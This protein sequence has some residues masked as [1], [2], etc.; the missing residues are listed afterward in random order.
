MRILICG[1]NGLLGQKLVQLLHTKNIEFLA[2]S[3]NSNK[4]SSIKDLN[5]KQVDISN[6]NLINDTILEYE[7]GIIINASGMTN[8]D[9]CNE[10]REAC[11]MNNVEGVKNLIDI[12]NKLNAHLIQVSTDF[13]FS[14]KEGPYRETDIPNPANFYGQSKLDAEILVQQFCKKWSIIRTVLVYG[15]T[16]NMSRS[17]IVLWVKKSLE[18]MKAIRVVSDQFR[19]PTLAEDLAWGCFLVGQKGKQGIFHISGNEMMSIYDIAI[20][21]A[22]FFK[23]DKNLISPVSSKELNEKAKRPPK[24]GFI[25]EKAQNDLG[26]MP[27]SFKEGLEIVKNQL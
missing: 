14:G 2:T 23:L 3:R 6:K 25:I 4:I 10:N 17:N 1:S 5:F 15:V 16:E 22:D 26:Y 13:V 8:V 11:I 18:E 19:T 21:V 27:R 12:S 20:K 9:E 24:T 7:P